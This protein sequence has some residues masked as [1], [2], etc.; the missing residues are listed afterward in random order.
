MKRSFITLFNHHL[1]LEQE[2][3][4]KEHL[5]VDNFIYPNS[6]IQKAW[7]EVPANVISL[8]NYLSPIISWLKNIGKEK[9]FL[10]VQGDFGATF[11]MVECAFKLGLIP[12]YATTKREAI[13]ET[14]ET[15]EI[16]ISRIF[17]HVMFR[18]YEQYKI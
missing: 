18:K 7:G 3:D 14:L 15:G 11:Y 17:K 6:E 8:K 4:A 16:K 9:D 5:L 2:L 10:L 1:T 12:I 13:E